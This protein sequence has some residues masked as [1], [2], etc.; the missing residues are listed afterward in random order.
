[1]EFKDKLLITN[2]GNFIPENIE[3]VLK[4]GFSS[5]YYRNQFLA[6]AMVNLN[7]I[8]IV[9]SGI[10]RVYNIQKEKF[11]PMPDYDL[12]ETNRVKVTLY[13]KILDENYSRLLFEKTSLNI[14]DVMLLD[15]VQK[16]YLIT[17]EQSTYLK[18]K[19]LIEG[20]YP[21]IY[22]S[23]NIAKLTNKQVNY[24]DNKGLDNAFYREIIYRFI[25]QFGPT[26]RKQI[27][28]LIKPKLSNI[29]TEKQLDSKIHFLLDSLKN[30]G[31]IVNV[32]SFRQSKWIIKSAEEQQKKQ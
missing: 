9:G 26:S 25:E 28:D 13:G 30:E 3:N 17:K 29:L 22:I 31:K 27:N 5:P 15:R 11:F 32:G 10:K 2:E 14:E 21:K 23:A 16:S 8:D 20:K 6:N 1:M 19:G 24:I 4:D 7:M 12:S 18:N